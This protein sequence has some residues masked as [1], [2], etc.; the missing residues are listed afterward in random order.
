MGPF[1]AM[2]GDEV[3]LQ[4][5]SNV[6]L[7]FLLAKSAKYHEAIAGFGPSPAC[8]KL[9]GVAVAVLSGS[10]DYPNALASRLNSSEV[11]SAGWTAKSDGEYYF[12]LINAEH[13]FAQVDFNAQLRSP[14]TITVTEALISE[15]GQNLQILVAAIIIVA[16]GLAVV[17]LVIF[18]RKSSPDKR[19]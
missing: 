1:R 10:V 17:G 8:E 16:L 5:V 13:E 4:A 3:S 6:S 9:F 15:D 18:R 14:R 7:F 2:V 12:V 19:A 11:Y